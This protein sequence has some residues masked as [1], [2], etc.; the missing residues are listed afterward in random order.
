LRVQRSIQAAY[1]T[2]V[3]FMSAQM[4]SAAKNLTG[5]TSDLAP[6]LDANDG[7]QLLEQKATQAAA[8]AQEVPTKKLLF[9][10][11]VTTNQFC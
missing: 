3:N 8:K 9:V 5:T 1:N 2:Q 7:M 11:L 6:G 4:L 10:R